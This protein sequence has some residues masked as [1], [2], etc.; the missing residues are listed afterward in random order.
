MAHMTSAKI[1]ITTSLVPSLGVLVWRHL[2]NRI[3]A[4]VRARSAVTC[5]NGHADAESA[6]PR[7]V[8]L[9]VHRRHRPR[10]VG[11][12]EQAGIC[13]AAADE[14]PHLR[15]PPG[16]TI[17]PP[18]PLERI[19]PGNYANVVS[20]SFAG[21]TN[22]SA[23]SASGPLTVAAQSAP[24]P[25]TFSGVSGTA[26]FNGTASLTAILTSANAPV[27]GKTVSFTLIGG[28][29]GTAQTDANGVATLSDVS[30]PAG[31]GA[32]TLSNAVGA[33]FAGDANFTGSSTT[34][35]LTV[36]RAT[37]TINFGPL[38][39]KTVGDALFTISASSS[40]NLPVSFVVLT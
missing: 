6:E 13:A 11:V 3:H 32:G 33:A 10:L 21:D 8:C 31:I 36:S 23:T 18:R 16:V 27:S 15:R 26:V 17:R 39:G 2:R 5:V 34:G 4:N 29:A 40:S 9:S 1:W 22:H 20:V 37:Q 28:S 35:P 38:G 12:G 7:L 19:A 30:L 24:P 14:L 25:A